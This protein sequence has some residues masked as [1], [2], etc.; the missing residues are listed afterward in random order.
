MRKLFNNENT[1]MTEHDWIET[2]KQGVHSTWYRCNN[3]NL[4]R[5]AR[6]I[7]NK[8]I[9]YNYYNNPYDFRD[10][11]YIECDHNLIRNILL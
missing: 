7:N 3:C 9:W 5:M 4:I 6:H 1:V 10:I 11:E 8:P 2:S